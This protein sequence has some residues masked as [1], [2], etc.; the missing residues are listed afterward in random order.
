ME[1]NVK[2]NISFREKELIS[3]LIADNYFV[4][5]DGRVVGFSESRKERALVYYVLEKY[6]D[7]NMDEC[8]EA[9]E[10]DFID[11]QVSNGNFDQIISK[12]PSN[13]Y[14]ILM[15]DIDAKIEFKKRKMD[16]E[17][18]IAVV[19]KV[20]LDKLIEKIPDKAEMAT[21]LENF[22]DFDMDKF[23][24]LKDVVKLLGGDK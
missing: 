9:N 18:N 19:I 14:M 16:E 7:L 6:S 10:D 20:F 12:I 2:K 24:E 1:I 3:G 8:D 11:K 5:I 15:K 21:I 13:E 22:K 4:E 17:N 23:G